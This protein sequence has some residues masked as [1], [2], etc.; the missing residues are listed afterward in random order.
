MIF[1]LALRRRLLDCWVE[2]HVVSVDIAWST[3]GPSWQALLAELRAVSDRITADHPEPSVWHPLYAI[4]SPTMNAFIRTDG[5]IAAD[6]MNYHWTRR[7]VLLLRAPSTP[8]LRS[9]F[10]GIRTVFTVAHVLRSR[11]EFAITPGG[12][13]PP[14]LWD[15]IASFFHRDW[16][17]MVSLLLCYSKLFGSS[18][19]NKISSCHQTVNHRS[20]RRREQARM[21]IFQIPPIAAM[22][23]LGT[24]HMNLGTIHMNSRTAVLLALNVNPRLRQPI[25]RHPSPIVPGVLSAQPRHPLFRHCL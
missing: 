1:S 7:N 10:R 22:G 23:D 12:Q 25:F 8:A 15:H 6:Y 20:C 3:A 21:E 4:L 14:E 16:F 24:M 11:I 18:C 5:A 19:N 2:Q 9:L 17:H 13:M